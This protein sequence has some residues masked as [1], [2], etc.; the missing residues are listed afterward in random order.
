M[1]VL[2][3]GSLAVLSAESSSPDANITD[4]SDALWWDFV[5]IATVGY[6]DRSPV[7]NEGR[8]VGVFVMIAGVGLFGTLGGF[9]AQAFLAP[10][11]KREEKA[12]VSPAANDPKAGLA[13]IRQMLLA[14]EQ[15]IA[16]LKAKLEDVD[17]LL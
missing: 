15:V 6:G 8:I 11:K 16:D 2:K 17:K 1:C 10:P 13:E 3:F 7:T 4:A 5:T 9:L 12:A 14:Q